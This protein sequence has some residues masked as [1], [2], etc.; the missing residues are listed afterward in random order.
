MTSQAK[1]KDTMNASPKVSRQIQLK[2]GWKLG[3]EECDEKRQFDTDNWR[4]ALDSK[5]T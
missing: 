4:V 5:V 3:Y 2:D 1:D